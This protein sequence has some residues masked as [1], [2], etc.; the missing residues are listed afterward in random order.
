MLSAKEPH[1]YHGPVPVFVPQP[2][3]PRQGLFGTKLF[4]EPKPQRISQDEP[5]RPG[6]DDVS[7]W[8]LGFTLILATVL[9]VVCI[10]RKKRAFLAVLQDGDVQI[11]GCPRE[12]G[13]H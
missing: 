11:K 7:S 6:K 3:P 10:S 8:V 2:A 4:A 5:Y 12:E 13:S 9:A 1:H